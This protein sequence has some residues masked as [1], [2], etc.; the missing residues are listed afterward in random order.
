MQVIWKNWSIITQGDNLDDYFM[1]CQLSLI[2]IPR[3]VSMTEN[4]SWEEAS[5]WQNEITKLLSVNNQ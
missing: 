4:M 1:N 2:F 5:E 3:N